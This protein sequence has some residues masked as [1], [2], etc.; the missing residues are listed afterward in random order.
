V[1]D[2]DIDRPTD[3]VMKQVANKSKVKVALIQGIDRKMPLK[4]LGKVNNLNFEELMEE[5]N[6]IVLSGTRLNIDYYVKEHIDEYVREEIYDYFM[7]A[8]NDDSDEAFAELKENDITY[9]EIR[10]VRL[11]F[12]SDVAN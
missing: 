8:K 2:N 9:D 6:A 5:L 1:D 4:E 11:K 3:F 10:I 12:L 7:E